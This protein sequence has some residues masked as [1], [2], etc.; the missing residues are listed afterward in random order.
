MENVVPGSDE[1]SNHFDGDSETE[2]E[3]GTYWKMLYPHV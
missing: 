2:S 1:D 3:L